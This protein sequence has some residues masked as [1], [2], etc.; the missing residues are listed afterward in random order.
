MATIIGYKAALLCGNQDQPWIGPLGFAQDIPE[1][2]G[3]N[4]HGDQINMRLWAWFGRTFL[5][6]GTAS[7]CQLLLGFLKGYAENAGVLGFFL[8][9]QGCREGRKA[10]CYLLHP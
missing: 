5:E 7:C 6:A 4:L 8:S 10:H 2:G 3:L 9:F 1:S